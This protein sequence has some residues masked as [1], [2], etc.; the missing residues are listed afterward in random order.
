MSV[1]IS[2][3]D[4]EDTLLMWEWGKFAR[5]A[6]FRTKYPEWVKRMTGVRKEESKAAQMPIGDIEP[7][8]AYALDREI[9]RLP[10]MLR[11][12]LVHTYVNRLT[13]SDIAKDLEVSKKAIESNK[14]AAL[15]ILYGRLYDIS[16]ATL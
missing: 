14:V 4:F 16:L 5:S 7:D 12:I 11:D 9:A 10:E 15:G 2:I 13:M 1:V 3:Q 6:W 8:Y